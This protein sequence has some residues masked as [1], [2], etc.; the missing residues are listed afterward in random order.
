VTITHKFLLL[1]VTSNKTRICKLFTKDKI[2]LFYDFLLQE[3]W[4]RVR[5]AV[6]TN[7]KFNL[8][9]S[10][11]SFHCNACFPLKKGNLNNSRKDNSWI[12]Q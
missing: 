12:T 8:F 4:D 5:N 7:D 3:S 2:N 9:F 1:P 6:D 11:L 10:K